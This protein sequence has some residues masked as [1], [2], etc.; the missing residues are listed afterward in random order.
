MVIKAP[1]YFKS[2]FEAELA[3]LKVL[4]DILDVACTSSQQQLCDF[5][6]LCALMLCSG[7]PGRPEG[8]L[9]VSDIEKDS[10]K[11]TWKPPADT[12]GRPITSVI[13]DLICTCI[14]CLSSVIYLLSFSLST[15]KLDVI[16]K[17]NFSPIKYIFKVS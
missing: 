3:I 13:N 9:K 11:L 10:A 5:D 12:G 1:D 8:P 2:I 17:S 7:P 4:L 6:T 15:K 14:S 16:F